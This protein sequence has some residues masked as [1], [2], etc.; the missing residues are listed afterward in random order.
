[1]VWRKKNKIISNLWAKHVEKMRNHACLNSKK[2]YITKK[3]ELS[4]VTQLN[5]RLQL[6]IH[7]LWEKMFETWTRQHMNL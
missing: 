7:S 2:I 1:M 5:T 4:S 3:S 6:T